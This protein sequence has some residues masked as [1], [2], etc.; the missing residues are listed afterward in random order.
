[1]T[2]LGFELDDAIMIMEKTTGCSEL[3]E[4][5]VVLA[6]ENNGEISIQFS[7]TLDRF[8]LQGTELLVQD[9]LVDDSTAQSEGDSFFLHDFELR[10]QDD[11]AQSNNKKQ[12]FLLPEI[13]EISGGERP[14]HETWQSIM[15]DSTFNGLCL[16]QATSLI[17][18]Q[19][20]SEDYYASPTKSPPFNR[21]LE[22]HR[23]YS[24]DRRVRPNPGIQG[25]ILRQG[26]SIYRK[27]IYR[28]EVV[29][30]PY[31]LCLHATGISAHLTIGAKTVLS[32]LPS[33]IK[34]REASCPFIKEVEVEDAIDLINLLDTVSWYKQEMDQSCVADN[35]RDLFSKG[36]D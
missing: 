9:C 29:A 19:V 4:S 27:S 1:M 2:D 18:N 3:V 34:K 17:R 24:R 15:S 35:W 26:S 14:L 12:A 16:F 21:S 25:S 36:Q 5:Q 10:G 23:V 7:Q 33:R 31:L 13:H 11:V 22:T 8:F 30:W 20:D 6:L 28:S 32:H